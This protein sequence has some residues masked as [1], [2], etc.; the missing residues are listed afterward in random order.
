MFVNFIKIIAQLLAFFL[1]LT[2]DPDMLN[3]QNYSILIFSQDFVTVS[4]TGTI[5]YVFVTGIC[6]KQNKSRM[7][8][9]LNNVFQRHVYTIN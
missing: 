3:T 6:Q 5:D 2:H 1:Y 9:E 8:Q 4:L 7:E